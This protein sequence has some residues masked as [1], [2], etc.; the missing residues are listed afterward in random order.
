MTIVEA[1]K[2][3]SDDFGLH[4][5]NKFAGDFYSKLHELG[6]DI[7]TMPTKSDDYFCPACGQ[8]KRPAKIS[9]TYDDPIVAMPDQKYICPTCM[10][11]FIVGDHIKCEGSI[12]PK[13]GDFFVDDKGRRLPTIDDHAAFPSP[14][15]SSRPTYDE[16]VE[17]IKEVA[18]DKSNDNAWGV[19]ADDILERLK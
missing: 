1:L 18:D 15:L 3:A 5:D 8:V 19:S 16:L 7:V 4:C 12:M 2:K 11:M 14:P 17:F 13:T 10:Q 6:F 9:S